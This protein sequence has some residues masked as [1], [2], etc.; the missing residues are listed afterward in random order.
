MTSR[1]DEL[2]RLLPGAQISTPRSRKKL[3]DL[4]DKWLG[5]DAEDCVASLAGIIKGT[6]QIK[7]RSPGKHEDAVSYALV[8]EAPP[9][10]R[11]KLE[12][13]SIVMAY[14]HGKPKESIE[15]SGA[16][17][18]GQGAPA[19]LDYGKLEDNELAEMERMAQKAMAARGI[20]N[21]TPTPKG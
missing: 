20:I 1:R 18:M 14:R 3:H 17:E 2:G 9:T 16:I 6:E 5:E 13:I 21:V 19:T 15:H 4:I 8:P 10:V 11:E 7:L 12:A